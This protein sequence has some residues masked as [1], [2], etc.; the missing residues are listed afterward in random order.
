MPLQLHDL[1]SFGNALHPLLAEARAN[2][3]EDRH[4]FFRPVSIKALG[5]RCYSAF[6]RY[7][8]ASE[9]GLLHNMELPPAEVE[10]MIGNGRKPAVGVRTHV[11][12]C[13]PCGEGWYIS[14]GQIV[15]VI[16]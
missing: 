16:A 5:G 1:R 8:S 12:R 2:M 7:L 3:R 14:D 4:P 15:S 13:Q 10:I 6:S 11:S 9:I